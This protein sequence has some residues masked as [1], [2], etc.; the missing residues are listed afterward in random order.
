MASENPEEVRQRIDSLYA[1]AENDTGNFNATRAMAAATR[2]GVPLA[3]Q[4]GGGS[5][6]A[7]DALA[8]QWFDA[9]RAKLGPTVPAALPPDRMPEI[10]PGGRTDYAA[11]LTAPSAPALG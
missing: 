5:D 4:R 8:Q 11:E 3:K 2:R 1:R 7:L 9:A 10:A 6:P